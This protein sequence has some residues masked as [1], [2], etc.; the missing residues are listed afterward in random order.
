MAHQR[1][2]ALLQFSA[3]YMS[4]NEETNSLAVPTWR[5]EGSIN[6]HALPGSEEEPATW[7]MAIR[8]PPRKRRLLSYQAEPNYQEP[9]GEKVIEG[10]QKTSASR[11]AR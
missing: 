11:H 8:Q 3:A 4:G 9:G 7:E 5:G 1:E 10:N 6:M 2:S